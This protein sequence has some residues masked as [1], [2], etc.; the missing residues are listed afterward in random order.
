MLETIEVNLGERRYG[1]RQ[2]FYWNN[3]A[4]FLQWCEWNLR[5]YVEKLNS[6]DHEKFLSG[7]VPTQLLEMV[8]GDLTERLLAGLTWTEHFEVVRKTLKDADDLAL[9]MNSPVGQKDN[10]P[11]RIRDAVAKA[12]KARCEDLHDAFFREISELGRTCA[13]ATS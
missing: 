2:E 12:E 10:L 9:W 1:A 11:K 5:P 8:R 4:G 13:R 3:A 6:T 7:S